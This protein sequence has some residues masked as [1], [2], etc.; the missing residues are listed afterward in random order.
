MAL[1]KC[2]A[3]REI[4]GMH[5]TQT[6]YINRAISDARIIPLH[7]QAKYRRICIKDKIK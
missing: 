4:G 7:K 2:S 3:R 5:K 1:L 6:S